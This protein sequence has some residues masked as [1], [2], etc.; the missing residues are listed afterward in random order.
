MI[1]FFDTQGSLIKSVPA[2]VYQ[3]SNKASRIWFVMP[4]AP[5]NVVNVAFTLPNG[6][7]APQ[8]IITNAT[9][10]KGVINGD[11]KFTDETGQVINVWYY[12]LLTD[13]TAYAGQTKVQFFVTA[14]DGTVISTQSVDITVLKG[15]PPVNPPAP[16]N[17]YQE[18]L[19]VLASVNAAIVNFENEVVDNLQEQFDELED[20]L[21]NKFNELEQINSTAQVIKNT[22]NIKALFN[23]QL[24]KNVLAYDNAEL[25][26]QIQQT[27][28]TALKDFTILDNSYATVNK[29]SGNTVRC[30]N[31]IPYP[32]T[33]FNFP[34]LDKGSELPS[35]FTL[36]GV[37]FSVTDNRE[38]VLSGV[39]TGDIEVGIAYNL[40]IKGGEEYTI[41]GAPSGSADGTY[42]ILVD[43]IGSGNNLS[44]KISRGM[45]KT[46]DNDVEYINISIAIRGGQR[47]NN[48]TFRPMFNKGA[49]LPYQP[50]F[51]GL[52]NAQISGIKSTGRNL[53]STPYYSSSETEKGITYTNN[54]DGSVTV[55]GTALST[56]TH[57]F[58]FNKLFK[59]GTYYISGTLPEGVLVECFFVKNGSF[60]YV[61][62][63]SPFTLNE[64]TYVSA[65]IAV[66]L[67]VTV[68][69]LTFYPMLNIG[70]T[71]LPYE[72]YTESIMSLP[73]PIELGKWD[74]IENGQIVRQTGIKVFDGTEDW[75]GSF[76]DDGNILYCTVSDV[77]SQSGALDLVSSMYP[78]RTSENG[79]PFT[80][81]F[82]NTVGK[83]LFVGFKDLTINSIGK[84]AYYL[85]KLFENNNPLTVAY[86]LET[87]TYEPITFDNQYLVWDKGTE[88]V[89]T[90]KD[91]K[92]N[93][94]FDYGANTTE[95][96][97]YYVI[98]GGNE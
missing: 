13:I 7:Y 59:A 51:T 33:T 62:A 9:L 18:I 57:T 54:V 83:S 4:T 94:S 40:P 53:I 16:A 41:S 44:T 46:I 71:A 72:P 85:K 30:E 49:V 11:N 38:I 36:K 21:N 98:V 48:L 70:E 6:Q 42:Y 32:Y 34:G 47:C 29:I 90:P 69:N 12:D 89:L 64:N 81:L 61:T 95:E 68:N 45:T 22:N 93:T 19:N 28:G 37:D 60:V 26:D 52:K 56:S 96:N 58:I 8:R 66:R 63:P 88:Q 23:L 15:T 65:Y 75:S 76:M 43:C 91:E 67:G 55:N 84:W 97:H 77:N 79:F 87:P 78:V 5:T 80:Y 73:N 25:T 74:Y 1:F 92:G 20:E 50:Y 31:L 17:E 35:L 3:G 39:A 10:G 24:N 82:V 86:K 14:G 2:N 27:G